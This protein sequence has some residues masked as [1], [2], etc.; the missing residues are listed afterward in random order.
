VTDSIPFNEVSILESTD[1]AD[2]MLYDNIVAGFNVPEPGSLVLVMLGG[3]C[4]LCRQ[5]RV[6]RG[7]SSR[8]N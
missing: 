3:A 2:G 6:R 5:R 4:A 1:M 8:E 7:S